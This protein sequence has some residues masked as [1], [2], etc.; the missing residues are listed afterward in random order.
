MVVRL[1]RTGVLLALLASCA[2]PLTA[3][4]TISS[5]TSIPSPTTPATNI[6]LTPLDWLKQSSFKPMPSVL[7]EIIT[8]NL[9]QGFY[10]QEPGLGSSELPG[11]HLV[12]VIG[13]E[14]QRPVGGQIYIENHV[15]VQLFS[16]D[17]RAGRT[18]HLDILSAQDYAWNFEEVSN[19]RVARY[20]TSGADGRVWI[21]GPFLIVVFSGLDDSERGPWVDTFTEIY[22]AQF[23]PP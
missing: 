7:P 1:L 11:G 2:A 5:P 19:Q 22:L 15:T 17:S 23:P 18:E 8:V 20:H 14:Y 9:P 16:Y 6:D 21:S 3:I 12:Q 13:V 10:A 4:P